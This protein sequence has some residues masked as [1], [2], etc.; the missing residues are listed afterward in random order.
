MGQI[1]PL[2]E[3]KAATVAKLRKRDFKPADNIPLNYDQRPFH[4]DG[5]MDLDI[6][7]DG[8]TMRTPIYI[9]M[10][11]PEQLLLSEGVCRQQGI[12]SYHHNIALWRGHKLSR[13]G[14]QSSDIGCQLSELV[15]CR[16]SGYLLIK[17]HQLRCD[18]V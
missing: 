1:L 17:A 8:K 12:V 16:V 13:S 5:R 18:S 3:L 7:F 6:S 10:D 14:T 2:L 11:T 15:W 9:K 4:L